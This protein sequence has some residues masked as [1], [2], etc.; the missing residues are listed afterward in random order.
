MYSLSKFGNLKVN[1]NKKNSYFL[2]V[3]KNSVPQKET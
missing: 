3:N 1:N 2:K